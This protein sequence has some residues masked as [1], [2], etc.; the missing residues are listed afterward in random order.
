MN[1]IRKS[2]FTIIVA[3]VFGYKR[4][5]SFFKGRPSK[6]KGIQKP[7]KWYEVP[8]GE[9]CICADGSRFAMYVK[10]GKCNNLFIHFSGG[11]MAWNAKSIHYPMGLK[12]YLKSAHIGFYFDRMPAFGANPM[13]GALNIRNMD[14]PFYGWNIAYIPYATGDFHIGNKTREAQYNSETKKIHFNGRINVEKSL[15]KIFAMYKAPEKIFVCGDSAGAFGSAFYLKEIADNYTESSIYYLSDNAHLVYPEWDEIA[16]FWGAD[17][18]ER[19]GFELGDDIVKAAFLNNYKLLG[20]KIPLL[21]TN[22]LRDIVL[23]QFYAALNKIPMNTKGYI[24]QWSANMC[25]CTKALDE[26]IPNYYYYITNNEYSEKNH[27]TQHVI[28]RHERFYKYEED[29]VPFYKWLGDILEDKKYSVG[30]K[31][32]N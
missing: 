30:E 13:G 3:C 22:T 9:K 32:I 23:T 16:D 10:N 4:L 12:S 1:I 6:I 19:F 17:L 18:K 31:Y 29:G 5:I 28:T 20:D 21:H 25:E 2:I 24:D 8:L 14:N 15:E 11:G 7:F 26:A 27:T